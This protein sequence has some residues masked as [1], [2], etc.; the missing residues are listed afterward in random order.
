MYSITVPG[1]PAPGVLRPSSM[2]EATEPDMAFGAKLGSSL[3]AT[4]GHDADLLVA[5]LE[6]IELRRA[7]I[8]WLLE[9]DLLCVC[10]V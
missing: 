5:A 8:E 9:A 7:A 10:L 6:D 4:A 2:P 1:S 3:E